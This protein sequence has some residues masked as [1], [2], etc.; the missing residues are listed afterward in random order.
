MVK[1]DFPSKDSGIAVLV[2]VDNCIGCRACQIACQEW[3]G[4]TPPKTSFSPTFTNPPT[5]MANAW[6]VVVFHEI[7]REKIL[8]F[9]GSTV[10][11]SDAVEMVPIPYNCLH[12]ATAPCARACPV[13]AIKV[14][15]EGA[16]VIEASECIGCGYCADACPYDVPKRGSD[17]KYYK[18]TFCVDRVQS[19]KA[20]AC[21]EV[22]PANVF[23]FTSMDNAVRLA[24]D[25][26]AKGKE[27]YGLDVDSYVGGRVRWIF[28]LSSDKASQA[29]KKQFP[30]RAVVSTES[31][32]ESLKS[33]SIPGVGI[34]TAAVFALGVAAWRRERMKKIGGSRKTKEKKQGKGSGGE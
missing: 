13:G 12:C 16:V 4:R 19:G 24:N 6:K 34:I 11:I 5:L 18:C 9:E 8:S 28:T 32:R 10:K 23:T 27:V 25:M 2:N 17:G 14:S 33:I 30:E 21:V 31:L 29:F 15:P 3:N 22:C 7:T 1:M 20:P 26:K